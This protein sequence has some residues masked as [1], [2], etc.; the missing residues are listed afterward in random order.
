MKKY[1]GRLATVEDAD[2]SS[3]EGDSPI[4]DNLTFTDSVN[5]SLRK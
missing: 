3:K 2:E 1:E 4:K 5:V